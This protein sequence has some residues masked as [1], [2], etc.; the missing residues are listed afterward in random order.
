[1]VMTVAG[2][3]RFS[4]EGHVIMI[5]GAA[6]QLGRQFCRFLGAAG[7]VVV[8]ADIDDGRCARL[9]EELRG[10]KIEAAAVT[11]D[12]ADPESVTRAFVAI[13][14]RF[15]RLD[16]LVNNAGIAVFTPFEDRSFDEFMSV[17]KVNAGGTFLCTQA[18][19][20]L[21][22]RQGSGGRIVNVG[23]IYGLVSGD[24]RVY[25]DCARNTAEVYAASKAAVIQMTRYWAVHL[26]PWNIRVNAISPGGIFNEQGEEFLRNYAYRTPVGRMGRDHE[27]NEALLFLASDASSY[28]TGHNLIVDGGW[29]AW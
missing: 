24:P 26:A 2:A 7:A 5:T 14:K 27:L 9:V 4:I 23:S 22:R 29:T 15:G 16:V 13:D 19:T 21:M 8:A 25:T 1:M 6:G 11:V 28:V 3:P 12:V 17:L 18:A 10:E 20:R